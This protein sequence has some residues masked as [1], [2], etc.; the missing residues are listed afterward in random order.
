MLSTGLQ[1]R[2]NIMSREDLM[3]WREERG[4]EGVERKIEE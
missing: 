2:T 1:R 4:E 3:R